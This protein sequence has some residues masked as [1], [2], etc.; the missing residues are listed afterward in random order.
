MPKHLK[1]STGIQQAFYYFPIALIILFLYGKVS[2]ISLYFKSLYLF[3]YS[4][5]LSSMIF[6]ISAVVLMMGMVSLKNYSLIWSM[7]ALFLFF[8]SSS[9]LM[10]FLYPTTYHDPVIDANHALFVFSILLLIHLV[11]TC[12]LKH[13]M[14]HVLFKMLIVYLLPFIIIYG[15]FSLVSGI[16]ADWF[17]FRLMPISYFLFKGELYVSQTLCAFGFLIFC[18]H[19]IDQSVN[20]FLYKIVHPYSFMLLF[21]CFYAS[22]TC[23]SNHLYGYNQKNI[24]RLMA[25]ANIHDQAISSFKNSLRANSSS[26]ETHVML[27]TSYVNQGRLIQGLKH[28][29]R[30]IAFDPGY[31]RAYINAGLI[32]VKQKKFDTAL[33]YFTQ[34]IW[35]QPKNAEAHHYLGFI[36]SILEKRNQAIVQFRESVRLDPDNENTHFHLALLLSQKKEWQAALGHFKEALWINPNFVPAYVHMGHLLVQMGVLNQAFES[37]KKALH[38][39]PG[40]PAAQELFNRTTDMTFK[41]AKKLANDQKWDE[42]IT[43]YTQMIDHRP[44]YSISIHYNIACLHAQKEQVDLSIEWL[45][46]AVQMGFSDWEWLKKDP[47]FDKIRGN[48][49]FDQ[50]V[51]QMTGQE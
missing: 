21:L 36:L 20:E 17:E 49:A 43:I 35:W 45:K 27:G 39:K 2:F 40:D 33:H 1:F 34:S 6:I 11:K 14:F 10:Q 3:R 16:V 50:F 12:W 47:D 9:C 29:N 28:F 30:A 23:V 46:K 22:H 19:L 48:Q 18:I 15:H 31:S 25:S 51:Q 41:Y 5:C 26:K 32:F 38:L 42:A 8:Q 7:F 44:D 24:G 4:L 13:D 37:F